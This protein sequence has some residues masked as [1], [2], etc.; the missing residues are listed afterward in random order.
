MV[1]ERISRSLG[2]DSA[3]YVILDDATLVFFSGFR[4]VLDYF[5][6]VGFC[7]IS[8]FLRLVVR[9]SIEIV[10]WL[11]HSREAIEEED[12]GKI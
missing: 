4:C 7:D 8:N 5:S 9:F 1:A 6:S 11:R 10:L 3:A 12:D 2:D